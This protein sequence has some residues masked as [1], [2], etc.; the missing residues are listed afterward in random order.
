MPTPQQPLML[1]TGNSTQTSLPVEPQS[2]PVAVAEGQPKQLNVS[3][4]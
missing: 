4:G 3:L 2:S 1:F